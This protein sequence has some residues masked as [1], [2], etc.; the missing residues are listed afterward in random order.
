M[1]SIQSNTQLTLAS[2]Y[3][4]VTASAQSYAMI[5]TGL[6]PAELAVELSDLQSKYLTTISQLFGWETSS[7]DT[8]P[9]TNPATGF[10]AEVMPLLRFLALASGTNTGDQIAATTPNTPAGNI[11]ATTVQAALNELDSEKAS[12]L[13]VAKQTGVYVGA[14]GGPATYTALVTGVVAY[15]DG[16]TID[17]QPA[18]TCG[19]SPT[20]NVNSLGAAS[21]FRELTSGVYSLVAAGEI[22]QYHNQR[23]TYLGTLGGFLIR[24]STAR[25]I[26]RLNA[27]RNM[28]AGSGVVA[29]TGAGFRPTK[30][31][32]YAAVAG[33]RPFS[34]GTSSAVAGGG[35]SCG[36]DDA[37]MSI[38]G[39]LFIWIQSSIPGQSQTASVL[40]MDADGF[41]LSW[42]NSG[43]PAAGSADIVFICEE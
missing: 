17:I 14:Q 22:Q 3:L 28:Q 8:V 31:T 6:L 13:D 18:T 24:G 23:L 9:M 40:Y 15:S 19:A 32:A 42:V 34:V 11:A 25:R 26:K 33:A 37:H 16:L 41:T 4:G 10:I 12:L 36:Q 21:I 27:T 38:G 1:L 2:L 43:S 7:A 5:H 39:S 30:I 29:Y 35:Y 20:I